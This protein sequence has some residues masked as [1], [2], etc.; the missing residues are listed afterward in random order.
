MTTREALAVIFSWKS[1]T[2]F[3]STAWIFYAFDTLMIF[4]NLYLRELGWSFVLIGA[5]SGINMIISASSRIIGGYIGDVVDRKMLATVSMLLISSFFLITALFVHPVILT[6]A[7]LVYSS[8]NLVKSG[9]SAYI[10]DNVPREHS[11]LALSLFSA[12]KVVGVGALLVFNVL[13]ATIGFGEGFRLIALVGGLCLLGSTIVRGYWLSPSPPVARS[14]STTLLRDFLHEN[15]TA[16]KLLVM[17]LPGAIII[18]LLDAISDGI[19]RF[20]ALL[21]ANEFLGVSI[22]GIGTIMIV[23]LLISVPLLFKVGRLAD[24]KGLKQTALFVYSLMPLSTILILVAPFVPVWAPPSVISSA[25]SIMP[26]LGAIFTTVFLGIVLKYVNDGLWWLLLMVLIR[27]SLPSAG[28]SKFLSIFW[29]FVMAL[30]AIGPFVGGVIFSLGSPHL[31]FVASLILNG[32]I[33]FSIARNGLTR[34][35]PSDS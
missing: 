25:E 18:V 31:L 13:V 24:T 3:L 7:L 30:A 22:P 5:L 4:Y 20:G 23:T 2:V 15:W 19:F 12:G 11:G 1:Y 34:H 35:I 32:I 33:I 6:F 28:T 29:F 9:S 26:G 10:M 17:T 8:L 21:Y 27:K 16:F 14:R